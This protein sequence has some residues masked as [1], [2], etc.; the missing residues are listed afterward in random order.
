MIFPACFFETGCGKSE[1]LN[2]N[3]ESEN[4]KHAK[5]KSTAEEYQCGHDRDV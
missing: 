3:L 5:S 1:N 2:H 4:L